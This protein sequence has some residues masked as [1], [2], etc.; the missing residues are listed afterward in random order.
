MTYSVH[1]MQGPIPPRPAPSGA[2]LS[3]LVASRPV[4]WVNT[5]YPF[6]AGYLMAGGRTWWLLVIGAVYFLIPYN[7]AMYGVNDVFD[8][9]SDLRNPRKGGI[10]G[11]VLDRSVHRTTLIAAA[12]SNVPFLV[13][14]VAFGTTASN[15][16]LAVT[17]FAV[18]AY[19]SPGLRFKERPVLDSLT[20]SAHFVGPAVVGVLLSGHGGPAAGWLALA[21]FFC[22]GVASHALG[23]IQDIGADR[24]GG[25]ASIATAFGARATLAVV[26]GA[27]GAAALLLLGTGWPALLAAVLVVPYLLNVLSVRS[28]T[29]ETCEIA[30]VAWRRF[31]WL[32]QVAGFGITMLLIWI[33]LRG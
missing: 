3:L 19:S 22:W 8:H 20:S 28:V 16:A 17:V 30:T 27:Y 10:H 9:A 25:I 6:A 11:A 5:A 33:H 12:L 14:L 18:V 2:A 26:L 7:L 21:A 1:P 31:L 23:A 24:D 15:L 32:N 13:I 4:S 29:D